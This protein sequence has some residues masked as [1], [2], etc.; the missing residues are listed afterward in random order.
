MA[1]D[2]ATRLFPDDARA[3]AA[4]ARTGILPFQAINH[5]V[6][7]HEIW[8][9]SEIAPDQVQPA[10]I[11]LRLG[12]TA[13]RVRASFLPGPDNTVLEKMEQLDAYPIDLSAGAVLE[14]GCVY[15]VPLLEALNL[16]SGDVVVDVGCG[17]GYFTPA[18]SWLYGEMDA[19]NARSSGLF[20][21][22]Y[23]PT[24]DA[25]AAICS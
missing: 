20:T 14:K 16:K 19:R 15:V 8:A 17:S 4:A 13:Y 18:L 21:V 1:E 6:R 24:Q 25:P 10:S 12:A 9:K 7:E 5:M 23:S 11:D 22:P 2:T 3:A